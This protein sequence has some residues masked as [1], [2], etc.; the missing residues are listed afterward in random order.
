MM[1]SLAL[2]LTL[3]FLVVGVVGV[4]LVALFVGQR[5]RDEFDRFVL[6]RAQRDL[7][8]QLAAYYQTHGDW[9]DINVILV[10]GQPGHMWSRG[11]IP[12]P[13]VLLDADSTVVY[14]GRRYQKG[15]QLNQ[16]V[17]DQRVPI[18]LE[19][20]TVGWLLFES[21]PDSVA[22][23]RQ[24]PESTF[25]EGVK[26]AIL[27]GALGATAVALLIGV[28]LARTISH[29]VR[30]LI[31][32]TRRVARGELGQQVPVRTQDE[33]GELAASFNQMSGDLARSLE[34]RRQMTADIAH[35]LRTPLS[36]IM[37]YTEALSD[38]KFQGAPE[39]F[40]ILHEEAQHLSRLVDDLRTLSLAD[41]GEL[42][43]TRRLAAPQALLA[44]AASAHAAQAQEQ[45]VALRVEADPDLPEIEVDPDRIAQVLDNL[46][47]N[48]LRYTPAGGEIVLCA[49]QHADILELRVRDSGAGIPPEE[50]PHIFDRFYRGEKSRYQKNGESGLGLAIARSIV[51]IHGGTIEVQSTVGAGT[52]FSIR[53]PVR[54]SGHRDQPREL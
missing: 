5:T 40:D 2:K 29:P 10:Q 12:A 23:L 17:K 8:D 26:Q 33:L 42:S 54:R 3:A 44:R 18:Q 19:E 50:L 16:Q 45:E 6:D 41:A 43:L 7:V 11:G 4:A 34:L 9:K 48:A 38:G 22:A 13:V 35:E 36:L 31:V 21:L 47:S 1:R 53:L 27:W 46:V 20:Q 15:T 28:L 30:E 32:A 25:L 51:E 37:G 14:G 49:A 52:T 39:T 24:S